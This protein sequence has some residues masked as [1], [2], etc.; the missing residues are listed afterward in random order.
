MYTPYFNFN[1]RLDNK[2]IYFK[3][4]STIKNELPLLVLSGSSLQWIN[5]P[6]FIKHSVSLVP[7]VFSLNFGLHYF[8]FLHLLLALPHK[9]QPTHSSFLN[10]RPLLF[11]H[12]P[13]SSDKISLLVSRNYAP[14]F[15]INSAPTIYFN[16]C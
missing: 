8:S 9:E 13:F 11:P 15:V 10:V 6:Y 2:S 7:P 5:S 16:V 3:L 1:Y 12:S 4:F 14:F